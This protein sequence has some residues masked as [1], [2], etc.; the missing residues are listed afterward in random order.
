MLD[1]AASK[2]GYVLGRDACVSS[3][4]LNRPISSKLSLSPPPNMEVAGSIPFTK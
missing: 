2:I 4:Q 1:I 3:A